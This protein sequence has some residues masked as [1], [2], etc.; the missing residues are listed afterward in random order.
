MGAG[1][2]SPDPLVDKL[3]LTS[4]D[5]KA[6]LSEGLLERDERRLELSAGLKEELPE[7]VLK[8]LFIFS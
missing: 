3:L 6:S 5:N 4:S 1:F 2:N 8:L 7:H